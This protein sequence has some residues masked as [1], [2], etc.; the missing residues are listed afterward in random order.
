VKF[1]VYSPFSGSQLDSIILTAD[2]CQ[3]FQ[4]LIAEV[5]NYLQAI[6]N[7]AEFGSCVK[8]KSRVTMYYTTQQ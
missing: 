6:Q 7:R 5:V 4:V 8:D 1:P 3:E 2:F